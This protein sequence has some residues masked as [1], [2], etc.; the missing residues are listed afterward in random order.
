MRGV[1]PAMERMKGLMEEPRG[2]SN[3]DVGWR[4]RAKEIMPE[5]LCSKEFERCL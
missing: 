5:G 2:F 1:S 3:F 4:W